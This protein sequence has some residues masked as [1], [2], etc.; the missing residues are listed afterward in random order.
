MSVALEEM[1]FEKR[2]KVIVHKMH[3]LIF[4]KNVSETFLTPAIIQQ[5]TVTHVHTEVFM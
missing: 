1:I 5:G 3:A 4:S 2:K